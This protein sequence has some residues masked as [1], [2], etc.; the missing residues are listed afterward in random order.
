VNETP[1]DYVG[2]DTRSSIL[3]PSASLILRRFMAR[4]DEGVFARRAE[5]GLDERRAELVAVQAECPG[6]R[7]GPSVA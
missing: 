7:V 6:L 3:A 2:V 4:S 5:A 1:V